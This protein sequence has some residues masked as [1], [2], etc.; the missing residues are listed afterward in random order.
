[1]KPC[2]YTP[3]DKARTSTQTALLELCKGLTVEGYREAS[4]VTG[5]KE[6]L[7]GWS[8]WFL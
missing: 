3:A 7:C 8:K 4:E 1:M 2:A 6:R 5:H